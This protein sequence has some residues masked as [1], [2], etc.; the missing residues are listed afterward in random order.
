MA[1]WDWWHGAGLKNRHRYSYQMLLRICGIPTTA[2]A[3][4][5]TLLNLL[6]RREPT[7]ALT[8]PAVLRGM[9]P[10]CSVD[11]S[12]NE[13]HGG[14]ELPPSFL[15]RVRP[16]GMDLQE[17]DALTGPWR[18]LAAKPSGGGTESLFPR[19]SGPAERFFRARRIW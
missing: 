8:F 16:A 7:A 1:G 18:T 3:Q 13:T 5:S 15:L 2:A 19:V 12:Y 11:Y 9:G 17:A 10:A 4:A 6:S 14:E